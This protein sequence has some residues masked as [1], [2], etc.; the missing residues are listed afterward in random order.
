ML[1]NALNV[2]WQTYCRASYAVKSNL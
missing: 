2:M 1:C